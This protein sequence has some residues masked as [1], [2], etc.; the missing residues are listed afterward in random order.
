LARRL[1]AALG[2][3]VRSPAAQDNAKELADR[4]LGSRREVGSVRQAIR[5]SST[6]SKTLDFFLLLGGGLG[7]V[8]VHGHFN[9]SGLSRFHSALV[10]D[11]V[12][13]KFE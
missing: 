7:R 2:Q 8:G 10:E 11:V 9:D 1:A 6:A 3:L 12:L 4:E 5:A 13:M